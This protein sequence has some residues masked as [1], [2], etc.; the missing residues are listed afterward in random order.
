MLKKLT[1]LVLILIL[2][3]F[4]SAQV[5]P[6]PTNLTV[7]KVVSSMSEVGAKL[8][9]QYPINL[10]Q[11]RIYKA[12]DTLPF[13]RL[14]HNGM[15]NNFVDWIVPPGHIYRYYVTAFNN[16][17]ESVPSNEVF[18]VPDSTPPP[19]PPM[20]VR[21]FI[22]G[23]I[24]DDSTGLPV[25]GVRL[26]FFRPNGCMYWREARTDSLGNYFAPLDTG[27]YLVYATKW[28]YLPEWFVNVL[29]RD[30]ATPVLISVGDTSTANF[31][32]KRI[33]L[34]PP[35]V[36]VS[37]SGTVTDSSNSGVPLKGAF[38]VFMRTNRV[39]NNMQ[40][41]DGLMMGNRDETFFMPEFGTCIGVLGKARTDSNGNYTVY[42]P[43][44]LSYIA[45]AVKPGY[46]P[47][48]FNNKR[49][50][51]DADQL[52][53]NGDTTGINFDL[54]LN[55]STQNS[56][57]GKVKNDLSEGVISRVVLFQR[58]ANRILPVRCT[59][60][61][62]LGNYNFNFLH[63][64]YY[65]A[66]AIP[67]AFYVPSW[68]DMDSCGIFRWVNA[69]SFM[70]SGS[71][72]GIDMCVL[73]IS[74]GGFASIGGSINET[75]KVSN[76]QGVTVYAVS[77]ATN[78]IVGYDITE[79]DGTFQIENLAPGTYQIVA[80]K[81]GFNTLNSPVYSLGAENN[82]TESNAVLSITLNVGDKNNIVPEKFA[83][84]QNYPNPFN[85]TTEISFALPKASKVTVAVYN[86]LGQQVATLLNGELIAGS[87]EVVWNGTDASGR[88]VGSGVYFYKITANSLDNSSKFSS[89]KKM[90]LV[91]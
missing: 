54:V 11:F 15:G 32:L 67:L 83:L 25:G 48:F 2:V 62:T 57:A 76:T 14:F 73:P 69:D 43:A 45:L 80:D 78:S 49:T 41:Y 88:S 29:V 8:Q 28:T 60:T 52:L 30:N 34:P 58:F 22:Q 6:P 79:A 12:V 72:T 16:N 21:G 46:I 23:N 27:K 64:G 86:L 65:F 5:I 53:I 74:F 3:G 61:D 1:L 63:S 90:L 36:W 81:E 7:E 42:V 66:K 38:I 47:E 17:G 35:P 70:V 84:N 68:Y 33:P 82:Y 91:K 50:P 26:R 44:G 20:F 39:L 31:G 77:L 87:H 13:I 18:F 40:N 56:L 55:P 85:P 75:G 10:V 71:T 37:V 19:P 51:F 9:W 89:V 59:V 4:V 24:V